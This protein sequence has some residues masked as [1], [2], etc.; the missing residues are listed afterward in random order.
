MKKTII[1]ALIVLGAI[2]CKEEEVKPDYTN[3]VNPT[4]HVIVTFNSLEVGDYFKLSG[5][6]V[7]ITRELDK[8]N[9]VCNISN[10]IRTIRVIND[11][12]D[13]YLELYGTEPI[14][15]DYKGNVDLDYL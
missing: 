5:A 10:N 3:G 1:L 9:Y 8:K 12:K 6:S 11:C 15:I 13:G 7:Y 2:S 4:D 14:I